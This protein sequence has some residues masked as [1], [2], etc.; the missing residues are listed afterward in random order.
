MLMGRVV[1]TY[2]DASARGP[3][4][5]KVRG[6]PML[7]FDDETARRTEAVYATPDVVAQHEGFRAV[8]AAR[9][10]ERVVDIGSGPGFLAAEIAEA[11]APGG[12]VVGVDPSES[13]L[14]L[15]RRR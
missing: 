3:I 5:V 15:A 4:P 2:Q 12:S 9:P 10:G 6:G 1:M 7:E 14:G 11:V 8:L 13:M